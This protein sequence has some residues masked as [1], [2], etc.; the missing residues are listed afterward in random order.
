MPTQA[1]QQ[2][3]N[4]TEALSLSRD[5]VMEGIVALATLTC[6]TCAGTGLEYPKKDGVPIMDLPHIC[7]ECKGWGKVV[8]NELKSAYVELVMAYEG[9]TS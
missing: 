8:P 7:R 9:I 6:K 3:S 2:T 4:G 1:V 5:T